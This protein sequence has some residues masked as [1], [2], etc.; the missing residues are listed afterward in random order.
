MAVVVSLVSWFLIEKTPTI[1]QGQAE[2]TSYKAS[3]KL[4]GRIEEMLVREGQK[5][6]KGDL[7]YVLSTPEIDAKMRQAKGAESA[8][9]AQERKANVG[10]RIQ[11]IEAARSMWIKA[12]SGVELA[13]KSYD[14]VQSLYSQGVLPA[15]KRDEAEA[16]YSA[17]R[18]TAAAARSQ[19]DMAMSGARIEDKEAAMALVRQAAGVVAEVAAYA[20][21]AKIYAP[22]DGEVSSVIAEQGELVGTG[23]PVVALVDTDDIWVSYNIKET[24]MPKITVG[25][26]FMAYIPALD[27]E[28]E[29]VVEYIAVQGDFATWSATKTQGGFDI[30]T[31]KVK[32]RPTSKIEGLRPGM[33]A[34]VDWDHLK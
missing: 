33:S 14:R 12:E 34:L 30:R 1:L 24:L 28:A 19:Y 7:L 20:E 10:A 6:S 4:S 22:A 11:E 25:K 23:Y 27:R 17:M 3:S 18:A 26:K 29:F 15:Q 13:K 21:D 2:A 16:N 9:A 32:T 5:V 8:A 31:F